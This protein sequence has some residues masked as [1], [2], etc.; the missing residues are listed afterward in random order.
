MKKRKEIEKFESCVGKLFR[1]AGS[2]YWLLVNV[3]YSESPTPEE[4]SVFDPKDSD[5]KENIRFITEENLSYPWKLTFLYRGTIF[6]ERIAGYHF[7]SRWMK[8][9]V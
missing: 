4:I 9:V 5:Y 6:Y 8:Q 7:F 3:L 2:E 1:I